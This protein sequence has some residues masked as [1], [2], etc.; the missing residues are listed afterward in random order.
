MFERRH[1]RAMARTL[2]EARNEII[3]TR[4]KDSYNGWYD[5]CYTPIVNMFAA[6]NPRFDMTRFAYA[7]ATGKGC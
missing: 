7:V 1:Y 5:Y 4:S 3:E 6:D 2:H